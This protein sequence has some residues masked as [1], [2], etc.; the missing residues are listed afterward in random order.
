MSWPKIAFLNV[1]RGCQTWFKIA[2]CLRSLYAVVI[3]FNFIPVHTFAGQNTQHW[4]EIK[5]FKPHLNLPPTNLVWT[6]IP[7][8]LFLHR[9]QKFPILRPLIVAPGV[10]APG[11]PHSVRPCWSV[12]GNFILQCSSN[13]SPIYA[14]TC[15]IWISPVSDRTYLNIL[16]MM[17]SPEKGDSSDHMPN[18]ALSQ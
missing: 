6:E 7:F 4:R 12:T 10:S 2:R 13:S 11:A 1:I 9:Y 18:W 16:D 14:H 17:K 5:N 15:K 3:H 8:I